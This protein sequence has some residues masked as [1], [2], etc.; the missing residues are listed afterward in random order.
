MQVVSPGA[1]AILASHCSLQQK[2]VPQLRETQVVLTPG[3]PQIRFGV[4][5]WSAWRL[6]RAMVCRSQDERTEQT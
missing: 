1:V 5:L 6:N 2:T 3:L 4:L